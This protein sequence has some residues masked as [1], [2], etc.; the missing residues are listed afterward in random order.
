MLVECESQ[1]SGS[2]SAGA[3]AVESAGRDNAGEGGAQAG[4]E[5]GAGTG[6]TAAFLEGG[7]GGQGFCGKGGPCVYYR[8]NFDTSRCAPG[9]DLQ[10]FWRCAEPDP[11]F[12]PPSKSLPNVILSRGA[13]AAGPYLGIASSPP[14]DL[15][16]AGQPLLEFYLSMKAARNEELANGRPFV[17]GL[18]VRARVG[19][20]VF[21]LSN[22]D[23]I[24]TGYQMWSESLQ[25]SF[26]RHRVD[27]SAFSGKV[28]GLDFEFRS[29]YDAGD[30][31]LID[32]VSVYDASLV[33]TTPESLAVPRCTP[34]TTRCAERLAQVCS[35]SG[36][37]Q[38]T[39]D[40]PYVCTD[41]GACGGVCRPYESS[42]DSAH[43]GTRLVCAGSGLEQVPETCLVECAAGHCQGV[44]FDEGFEGPSAP[45]AWILAGDWSIAKA[46]GIAPVLV[47]EDGSSLAAKL[48]QAQTSRA[49]ADNFAQSS[50]VDL[51]GAKEPVLHFLA[52]MLTENGRSGFDVWARSD[53]AHDEFQLL[54]PE[55]PAYDSTVNGVAAWSGLKLV[56][57]HFQVD[58]AQFVGHKI[59]L[60]FALTSDRTNQ[61]DASI[62]IERASVREQAFVPLSIPV[63]YPSRFSAVAG[64]PFSTTLHAIGG[65]SRAVWSIVARTDA[66]G[67]S[68]DAQT[69]TLSGTPSSTDAKV[70]SITVRIAE[71]DVKDNFAE[72]GFEVEIE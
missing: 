19:E 47:S 9:W 14:I 72:L 24:Y 21:D 3:S 65:S 62:Y 23:P 46:P 11:V 42:C 28:I 6:G 15:S 41:D 8:E 55:Y 64:E 16:L 33:P 25:Y 30:Q 40:C 68:L 12:E 7:A 18:R 38:S 36:T 29:D 63:P 4:S 17:S 49:Y 71:P 20:E 34:Q 53:G 59:S 31:V 57:Q 35:S 51:T 60:R 58:L 26:A 44:Y 22:V 10:G 1:R 56:F 5:P 2:A 66:D 27:L 13:D 43:P 54:A 70:A 52:F 61:G 45:P 37:W 67:L 32:D 48:T 50:E 39:E 69:G